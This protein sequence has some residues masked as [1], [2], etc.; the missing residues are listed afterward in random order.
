[1]NIKDLEN[2]ILS[3]IGQLYSS[4]SEDYRERVIDKDHVTKY[5]YTSYHRTKEIVKLIS[6]FSKDDRILDIGIGYG[7]YDIILKEAFGFDVSGTEVEENIASYCKLPQSFGINIIRGELSDTGVL[8]E[9]ESY[10]LAVFS[11]VI[12]HLRISPMKALLEIKNIL[13]PGGRLILTTPNIAGLTNILKLSTGRNIIEQFPDDDSGLDHVTDKLVHI[14][15]YTMDELKNLVK[16]AGFTV[17]SAK[18]SISNDKIPAGSDVDLSKK[19]LRSLLL[20]PRFI[21]PGLRSLLVIVCR[22]A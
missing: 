11:E 5:F 6:R 3:R 13:K 4:S 17:E 20:P 19:I 2:K 8:A 15:E 22:K 18:F 12:E 14:R 7:F 10:D 21:L 16:R 1:M 9:P